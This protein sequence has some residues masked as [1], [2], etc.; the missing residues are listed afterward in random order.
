M[1]PK[2]LASLWYG[3]FFSKTVYAGGLFLLTLTAI[4][5]I[6]QVIPVPFSPHCI[7][8]WDPDFI[9]EQIH[10][11]SSAHCEKPLMLS[12]MLVSSVGMTFSLSIAVATMDISLEKEY[13]L[14]R[15]SMRLYGR[16]SVNVI[17]RI[18]FIGLW[19]YWK[20]Q[21]SFRRELA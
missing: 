15:T 19:D 3:L 13:Y 8:I 7:V 21:Q 11:N 20:K 14:N 16:K 18:Q 12:P 10:T 6:V 17:R 9:L 2:T 1:Y 4:G 5:P